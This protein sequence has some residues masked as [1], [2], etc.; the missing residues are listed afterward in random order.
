MTPSKLGGKPTW[1]C[2]VNTPCE[3]CKICKT[4]LVFLG[5]IEGDFEEH[6]DIYRR[7]LYIFVCASQT[8]VGVGRAV[9]YRC[10][11]EEH[12]EWV[13]FATDK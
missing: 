11:I 5:Q 4:S 9:V 8:C 7:M 2:P 13:E 3:D 1:L 6:F 12:N 10:M